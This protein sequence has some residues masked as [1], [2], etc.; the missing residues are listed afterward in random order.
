MFITTLFY[1]SS[2]GSSFFMKH[3]LLVMLGVFFGI[4]YV[5]SSTVLLGYVIEY[6]IF[7]KNKILFKHYYKCINN[8]NKPSFIK[9]FNEIFYLSLKNKEK[10][11]DL[12]D[13]IL[14]FNKEELDFLKENNISIF[15]EIEIYTQ[16]IYFLDI[17]LL[18]KQ[19]FN[20]ND[21]KEN[22]D[23]LLKNVS[24]EKKLVTD[25]LDKFRLI[26]CLKNN[27]NNHSLTIDSTLVH[28]F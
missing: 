8:N 15:D 21:F 13:I 14:K 9:F 23:Y 22:I 25:A 12:N 7:L 4:L 27:N 3:P 6:F 16:L 20:Y 24:S 5:I 28:N 17:N 18:K 2:Y 1:N 11:Y 10:K 19:N 26:E